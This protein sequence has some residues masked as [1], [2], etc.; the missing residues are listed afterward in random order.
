MEPAHLHD[1]FVDPTAERALIAAAAREGTLYFELIDRLPEKA[2]HVEA[3]A[4]SALST[5]TL[6]CGPSAEDIERAAMSAEDIERA[7]IMGV[8]GAGA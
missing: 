4:W 7:A 2:F 3:A 6:N 5:G 8:D 1:D